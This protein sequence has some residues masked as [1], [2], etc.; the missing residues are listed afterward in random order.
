MGLEKVFRNA[1]LYLQSKRLHV[2]GVLCLL[3]C[4]FVAERRKD[5]AGAYVTHDEYTICTV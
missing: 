4:V 3:M 2:Q 5:L 1:L